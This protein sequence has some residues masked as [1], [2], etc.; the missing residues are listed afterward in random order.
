MGRIAVAAGTGVH[1]ETQA[2]RRRESRQRK[3]VQID[4]AV[5]QIP[6]G[7]NLH[8]QTSF[9]KVNLDLVGALLQ[10]IAHLCFVLVQ[11]VLDERFARIAGNLGD[12][13]QEA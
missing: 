4:E 1:A 5:Q 7:I 11:E 3:I 2:L 10:T 9:R 6:A 12:G 8:R 13:I